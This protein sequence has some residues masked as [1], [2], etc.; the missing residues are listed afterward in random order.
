MQE[1]TMSGEL[2]LFNMNRQNDESDSDRPNRSTDRP[3]KSTLHN[4]LY[5]DNQSIIYCH[6]YH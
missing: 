3:N 6:T 2:V 5:Y 4:S 1:L